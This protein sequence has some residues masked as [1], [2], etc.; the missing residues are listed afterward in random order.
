MNTTEF[1]SLMTA[2]PFRPFRVRFGSGHV[3]DVLHRDFVLLSPSNRTAFV[4][5]NVGKDDE[6]CVIVD[7]MLIETAEF[8]PSKQ[9][10]KRKSA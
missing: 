5:S 2:N 3:V 8:L 7:V 9:N 6:E 4:Y 10:G 1:K